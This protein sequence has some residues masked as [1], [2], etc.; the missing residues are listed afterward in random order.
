VALP[1]TSPLKT[2]TAVVSPSGNGRSHALTM[3]HKTTL[4][5]AERRVKEL[6]RIG[7]RTISLDVALAIIGIWLTTPFEGGRHARR[8]QMIEQSPFST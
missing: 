8:V 7:E 1:R 2:S 3:N 6:A 4:A 5:G